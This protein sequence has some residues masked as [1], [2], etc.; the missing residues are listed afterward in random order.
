MI[1][2]ILTTSTAIYGV[3]STNV[4]INYNGKKELVIGKEKSFNY[5][6]QCR[7]ESYVDEFGCEYPPTT[8]CDEISDVISTEIY[9]NDNTTYIFDLKQNERLQSG[10][11]VIPKLQYKLVVGKEVDTTVNKIKDIEYVISWEGPERQLM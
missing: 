11:S 8:V 3:E 4:D 9:L 6:F 1:I 10:A 5:D 2:F 7:E